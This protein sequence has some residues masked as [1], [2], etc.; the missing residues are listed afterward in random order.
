MWS[1]SVSVI[2]WGTH[3][4]SWGFTVL[5]WL[6]TVAGW[7]FCEGNWSWGWPKLPCDHITPESRFSRGHLC[8]RHWFPEDTSYLRSFCF[9]I[10][11][12]LDCKHCWIPSE[13]QIFRRNFFFLSLHLAGAKADTGK[14][15]CSP[16][17]REDLFP[18]YSHTTDS[19]LCC[20][21]FM[22]M[23]DLH[24]DLIFALIMPSLMINSLRVNEIWCYYPNS[25]GIEPCFFQV[26]CIKS[27]RTGTI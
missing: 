12:N 7:S 25:L 9:R 23:F 27:Y 21:S 13:I 6:W 17:L 4:Q 22:R 19:I 14:F 8:V 1:F 11:F 15:P 24:F 20:L 5:S 18:L 3:S 26:I 16:F 10:F 2:Q